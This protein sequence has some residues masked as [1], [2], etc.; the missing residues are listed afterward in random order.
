MA[1]NKMPAEV[2]AKFKADR[3]EKKAPS[4]DEV[5]MEKR[6]RAKEKA[7]SHKEKK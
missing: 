5:K 4:G 7:R 2:L 1:D 3:E 6:K